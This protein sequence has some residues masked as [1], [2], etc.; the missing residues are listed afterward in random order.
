M[1]IDKILNNPLINRTQLA[2]LM[3]PGQK[4][5]EPYLNKKIHCK[6]GQSIG[7]KDK[8]KIKVIINDL[9]LDSK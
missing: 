7:P 5:P 3:F 2:R 9:I 6:Q 4:Y 1:N 8:E